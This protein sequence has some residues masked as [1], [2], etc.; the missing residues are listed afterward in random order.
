MWRRGM[1]SLRQCLVSFLKCSYRIVLIK[2]PVIKE[3][4]WLFQ[5]PNGP[6]FNVFIKRQHYRV[7]NIYRAN[8]NPQCFKYN[9]YMDFK[10]NMSLFYFRVQQCMKNV[11]VVLFVDIRAI[12]DHHCLFKLSFHISYFLPYIFTLI[13]L[14]KK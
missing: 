11:V 13:L 5:P 7:K 3:T 12:V 9:F 4:D 1:V 6:I 10:C 8:Q 14:F 2:S